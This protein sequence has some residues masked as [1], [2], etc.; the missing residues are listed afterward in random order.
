MIKLP[1][2]MKAGPSIFVYLFSVSFIS[3][4]GK[5]L[6]TDYSVRQ[7]PVIA[8]VRRYILTGNAPL[9]LLFPSQY[10]LYIDV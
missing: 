9:H 6:V 5:Q 8:Q 7:S 10:D 2:Y 4:R 3:L 1:F